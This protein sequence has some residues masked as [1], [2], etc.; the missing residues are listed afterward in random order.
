MSVCTWM[1]NM[2]AHRRCNILFLIR[3]CIVCYYIWPQIESDKL[4]QK[5]TYQLSQLDFKRNYCFISVAL[6][7]SQPGWS[8][9]SSSLCSHVS[10]CIHR[11]SSTAPTTVTTRVETGTGSSVRGCN[12]TEYDTVLISTGT[13][14]CGQLPSSYHFQ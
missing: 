7:F 9:N 13:K 6:S 5:C 3:V 4:F 8:G 1:D 11:V 14:L 10:V 12:V 2:L